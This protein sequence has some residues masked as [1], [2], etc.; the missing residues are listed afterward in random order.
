[1]HT[2]A[3]KQRESPRVTTS[4]TIAHLEAILYDVSA[5]KRPDYGALD[6]LE[7]SCSRDVHVRPG[8]LEFAPRGRQ[9]SVTR[10]GN[11]PASEAYTSVRDIF[12]VQ[13]ISSERGRGIRRLVKESQPLLDVGADGRVSST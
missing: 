8:L 13:R 6:R 2:K 5:H 4:A 12:R 10:G 9:R 11:R 7:P 1:L 3:I